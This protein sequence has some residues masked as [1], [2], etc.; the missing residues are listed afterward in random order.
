MKFKVKLIT[1]LFIIFFATLHQTIVFG[2]DTI[3]DLKGKWNGTAFLYVD[4][5][6]FSSIINR[7]ITLDVTKQSGLDFSG[8]MEVNDKGVMR[9]LGFSQQC[10]VRNL[11]ND[12]NHQQ[13]KRQLERNILYKT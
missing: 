12:M 6:G 10:P 9:K 4:A 8:D 5:R 2:Q 1:T 3:P 11:H 7:S 13:Y